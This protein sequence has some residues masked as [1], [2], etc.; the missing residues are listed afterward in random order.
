MTS[1]HNKKK[2]NTPIMWSKHLK[3]SK[4]FYDGWFYCPFILEEPSQL[5]GE[6]VTLQQVNLTSQKFCLQLAH[7]L[8]QTSRDKL[9]LHAGNL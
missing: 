3:V 1:K 4:K 9:R 5:S 8:S 7:R 2:L 6:L